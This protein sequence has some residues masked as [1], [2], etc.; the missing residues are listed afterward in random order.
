[1][2]PEV[3][4]EATSLVRA[5]PVLKRTQ[6]E[7]VPLLCDELEK[8]GHQELLEATVLRVEAFGESLR[9]TYLPDAFATLQSLAAESRELF[10]IEDVCVA[11]VSELRARGWSDA[12][13]SD[14]F[15]R[16]IPDLAT[17]VGSLRELDV[18]PRQ[19][20]CYAAVTITS[21]RSALEVA[22][23]ISLVDSL[24]T[25]EVV[26][27]PPAR[28]G[29]YARLHVDAVDFRY[30]AEAAFSQVSSV[31]GAAAVFVKTDL[32]VRSSTVVVETPAGLRSFDAHLRLPRESRRAKPDQLKR[33]VRS[34]ADAAATR[35]TD[36][37]FDA[38][39]HRQRAIEA[40][41]L[42][43]R[44]MLLW[45]GIERLC[46]GSPDHSTILE[47]VRALVPPAIALGKL[48]RDIASFRAQIASSAQRR[49]TSETRTLAQLVD[50]IRDADPRALTQE[51]YETDVLATQWVA[52]LQKDLRSSDGQRVAD[53]FERSRERVEWQVL[54]LYRAR[55]S[56]AH[57]ARGPAWLT[58]LVLHAHFYLT[59]LIAI[60]VEHRDEFVG[61]S[62]A[63]ILLQRAA[64]YSAFVALLKA[65]NQRALA[66]A[67]LLRPTALVGT[68]TR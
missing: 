25:G 28:T 40:S 22:D 10:A 1:M 9:R 16:D 27:P 45:L 30:A 56:V 32:L 52:R 37:I 26:G 15:G 65:N 46:L 29:P 35:I 3:I 43:S 47:S 8:L 34:A 17:F 49:E 39:R 51:F 59:Q 5:D 6:S 7:L 36:S 60:C 66:S 42:E 4:R 54:R 67:S 62:S 41:D 57:A 13:L 2:L 19:W 24:P 68:S 21:Q 64:Q 58:D 20:T 48:R 61:Q 33:I 14:A 44:F 31:L 12:S 53:Y 63:E 38:I 55:N 18:P 50:L 23:R 11:L